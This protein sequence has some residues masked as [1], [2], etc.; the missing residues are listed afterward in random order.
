MFFTLSQISQIF[1]CELRIANC[2]LVSVAHRLKIS[3]ATKVYNEQS[4]DEEWD[5]ALDEEEI[6]DG[7]VG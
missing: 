3:Q 7:T 5:E 4:W 2:E 1:N 6:F